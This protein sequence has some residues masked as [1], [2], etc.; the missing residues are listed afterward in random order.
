MTGHRLA[1]PSRETHGFRFASSSTRGEIVL[2]V[3]GPADRRAAA[4]GLANLDS[5][6]IDQNGLSPD[7]RYSR[8]CCSELSHESKRQESGGRYAQAHDPSLCLGSDRS[9]LL[10]P[11]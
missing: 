2:S 8:L 5:H 10:I 11:A 4:S 1:S 6:F 3:F 9:L 7:I